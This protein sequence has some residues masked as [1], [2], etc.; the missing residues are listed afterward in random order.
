[1]TYGADVGY[2]GF[3]GNTKD[4]SMSTA[5]QPLGFSLQ[6]CVF[7][8]DL[9]ASGY[10]LDWSRVDTRTEPISWAIAHFS[11]QYCPIE[12]QTALL[13]PSRSCIP[14]TGIQHTQFVDS[15]ILCIIVRSAF[16]ESTSGST[17][18]AI[19][20]SGTRPVS[21]SSSNF[22]NCT[23][24]SDYGG[25][26]DHRGRSLGMAE[27]CVRGTQAYSGGSAAYLES[28]SGSTAL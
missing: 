8:G 20:S 16:F 19:Y 9:P 15:S 24:T 3:K 10:L 2:G 26:I 23:A 5:S 27:C 22:L 17:G 18:G 28:G 7:A 11:A 14:V 13:A 21:V 6:D 1:L 12:S 4:L 25:A